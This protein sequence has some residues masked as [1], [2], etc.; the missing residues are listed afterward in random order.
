ME[1]D[2]LYRD[3][4]L[5]Q[6]NLRERTAVAPAC[7]SQTLN[8]HRGRSFFDYVNGWRIE[9]AC[10]QPSDPARSIAA[11]GEEVGFRP[12]S[13]FHSAL[14]KAVGESVGDD[15]RHA[16]QPPPPMVVGAGPNA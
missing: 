4:G 2:R 5:T 8:V 12:C 1:R 10:R 16:L 9:D 11:T 7:L 13:M 3:T 15:R 14:R 6:R